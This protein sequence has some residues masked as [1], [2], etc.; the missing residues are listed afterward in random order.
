[1]ARLSAWIARLVLLLLAENSLA[2]VPSRERNVRQTIA[3]RHHHENEKDIANNSRG[4]DYGV[5]DESTSMV[6]IWPLMSIPKPLLVDA[7][8]FRETNP[9]GARS[10]D[11]F[12]AIVASGGPDDD[13]PIP[14]EYKQIADEHPIQ[15]VWEYLGLKRAQ[16]LE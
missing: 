7:E 3:F 5:F 11:G 10:R 4:F 2:W 16:P 9:F 13:C 6:S 8:L 14:P 1:M 15:D 12:D